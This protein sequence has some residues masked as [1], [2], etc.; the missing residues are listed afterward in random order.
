L[1]AK[2]KDIDIKLEDLDITEKEIEERNE[3]I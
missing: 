3:K 1:R 2:A